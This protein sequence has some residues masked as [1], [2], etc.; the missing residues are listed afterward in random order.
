MFECPQRS[1]HG[2][3]DGVDD[4]RSIHEV[5]ARRYKRLYDQDEVFPDILLID[6]ALRDDKGQLLIESIHAGTAGEKIPIVVSRSSQLVL[7]AS[8]SVL[9]EIAID[10]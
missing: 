8:G 7:Q 1:P 3:V 10:H 2:G 6:A 9:R 4:F 5:V